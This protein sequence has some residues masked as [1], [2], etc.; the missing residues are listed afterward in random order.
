MIS[1]DLAARRT[2]TSDEARAIATELGIDFWALGRDLGRWGLLSEPERGP[3]AA[4]FD[5]S[6]DDR[7][8]TGTTALAHRTELTDH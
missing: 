7:S 6:G 8:V 5:V 1:V 2:F 4:R 3:R